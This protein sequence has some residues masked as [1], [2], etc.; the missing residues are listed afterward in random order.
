MRKTIDLNTAWKT[1]VFFGGAKNFDLPVMRPLGDLPETVVWSR[2][3]FTD[4]NPKHSVWFL[5]LYALSGRVTVLVDGK[6]V[7]AFRARVAPVVTDLT[8]FIQKGKGQELTL[9]ITPE[10]GP[11]GC[12]TFGRARLVAVAGSHFS[13]DAGVTPLLVRRAFSENGV[14][15]EVSADVRNPNNY[16]VVIF[17]LYSP[18]GILLDTVTAK[19][20]DCK[21]AFFIK[22]PALWEGRHADYRYRVDAVLQRDAAVLDDVSVPFSLRDARLSDGFYELGGLKLPLFGVSLSSGASLGDAVDALSDLGA[23]A[24]LTEL[25]DP[26]E[27]LLDVADRLG[28]MLAYRFPSTGEE[29]DFEELGRLLRFLAPH[30]SVAFLTFQSEDPGYAKAFCRVV[31][32]HADGVFTAVERD[33]FAGDSP[34]LAAP[35]AVLL[36]V[37]GTDAEALDKAFSDLRAAHPDYRFLVSAVPPDGDG[38]SFSRWHESVWKAFGSKKGVLG[39]FA[40]PLT[41]GETAKR[42]LVSADFDLKKDA[43]WFYR[44]GVSPEGFVKLATLP[45]STSEKTIDVRC[46]SNLSGLRLSVGGKTDKKRVPVR[47]GDC[48]YVFQNVKLKRKNNTL[49]LTGKNAVDSAVVYRRK[50]DK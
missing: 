22:N 27:R 34:V 37:D 26:T 11:D 31:R 30:P 50:K 4:D 35:D 6:E 24:V 28:L 15:V 5:E 43:F 12:F 33:L 48:V 10:A 17:R 1:E 40:G 42:G 39:Y 49:V 46:Y 9:E 8:P 38:A 13:P 36:V 45:S 25:T 29:S 3:F 41:D 18:E 7:A 20:T 44:T 23:T 21:A 2:R 47:L 32:D 14:R 19:P 16:D